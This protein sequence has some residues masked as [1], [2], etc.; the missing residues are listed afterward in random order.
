MSFLLKNLTY[1][2]ELS[3]NVYITQH[4]V[5][6]MQLYQNG[7][8]VQICACRKCNYFPLNSL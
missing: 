7:K 8:S 6:V 5:Q 2:N 3:Q 1:L 4:I